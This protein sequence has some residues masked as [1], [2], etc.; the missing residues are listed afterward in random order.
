MAVKLQDLN[1]LV[2][3]SEANLRFAQERYDKAVQA[4]KRIA[5]LVGGDE[6]YTDIA[7]RLHLQQATV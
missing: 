1:T 2:I 5:E 7:K 6:V 3:E 4:R